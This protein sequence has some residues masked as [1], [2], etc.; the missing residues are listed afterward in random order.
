MLSPHPLT[1]PPIPPK[2]ALF[3]D[4]LCPNPGNELNIA[5]A[6]GRFN[7]RRNPSK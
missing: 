2:G 4:R 1:S 3:R 7:L 6:R 5:G